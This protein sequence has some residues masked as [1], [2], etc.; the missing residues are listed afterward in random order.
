VCENSRRLGIFSL[1]VGL[2][3]VSMR[4]PILWALGVPQRAPD[5]QSRLEEQRTAER[6]APSNSNSARGDAR[7]A[8]SYLWY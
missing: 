7:R 4:G 5:R 1:T 8:S 6:P 3:I 2:G